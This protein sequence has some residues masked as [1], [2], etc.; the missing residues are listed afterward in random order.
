MNFG[1]AVTLRL[2]ISILKKEPTGKVRFISCITI[3]LSNPCMKKK[4]EL[5]VKR[6]TNLVIEMV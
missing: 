3:E 2:A 6:F 5:K 1:R 4:M